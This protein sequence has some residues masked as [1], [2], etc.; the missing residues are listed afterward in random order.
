MAFDGL[1]MA[2]VCY[3][4][5]TCLVGG[6]IS[7]ISMPNK[8]ELLLTIK[9]MA[10][11]FRLLISANASLPLIYLS[12]INKQSPL[13]APAFC[14]FLRKYIGTAKITDIYMESLER[15]IIIE[16]EHNDELGDKCRKKLIFEMMGKHSNI[17]FC[18]ENLKIL[19]S[20][21]RISA[22][23]SS[24]REV[25]PAR[26]YFLPKELQKINP[27]TLDFESFYALIKNSNENILR[28]LYLNYAG[29]SPLLAEEI[30]TRANIDSASLASSLREIEYKHLYRTFELI[31]EDIKDNRFSPTIVYKNEEPI[32]FSSLS[33]S[34]Y[35]ST[36]FKSIKFESISTLIYEYYSAKD[37][38]IRIKQKS[39]DLRKIVSTILERNVKKFDLQ[40]K[41]LLD[42]DKM[43][44]FKVYGDLITT[45]GYEL[46]GGEK[47]LLCPNY[48][49]DNKEIKISLDDTISAIENAKKYYDKYAKL[50]RTRDALSVQIE[51]TQADI[52][53]LE[54]IMTSL[55]LASDEDDLEQIR[56]EL[57]DFSYIKKTSSTKKTKLVSKPLHFISSDGFHIFVGK[58]N[59]QNEEL[60]FKL[61]SSN[62]WWFHAKNV[63]GS[64]VIVK[65]ENKELSDRCFEEAAALAAFYSSN[66]LNQKVEV[67]YMQ[68]KNL[69]KVPNAAP[70]FV[71]YH[72]N[73]SMI[74]SP[75]NKLEQI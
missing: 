44:K 15:I 25:L 17:I 54:S 59:F 67:D 52:K 13:N 5:K 70:G 21:K 14:M 7:K 46:K 68:K 64:H 55:D 22:S 73:W 20:I 2:N 24:L 8:D 47:E 40:R 16:L 62:D 27:L 61:A 63:A 37:T 41:Q 28:F 56:A 31:M 71:I 45:Y 72:N 1:V 43:D 35:S 49:D 53:H 50:K 75:S 11:N 60:S 3:E 30:C 42:S 66:R 18:D 38:Y 4:L 23:T 69:K 57:L 36:L 58:N 48:Y 34:S 12:N 29:I 32:E 9:N 26:T 74:V 6:R 51:K 10:K 19:D 39:S 33:L 65:A